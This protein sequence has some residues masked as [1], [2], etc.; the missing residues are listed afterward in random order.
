MNRLLRMIL[1][2]LP[3]VPGAYGKLCRYA[4]HPENYPEIEMWQHIQKVLSIVIPYI[5]ACN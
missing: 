4:K 3:K 1:L 2:N 5:M